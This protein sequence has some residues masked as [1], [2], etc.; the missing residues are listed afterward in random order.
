M[1]EGEKNRHTLG[2]IQQGGQRLSKSDPKAL[3]YGQLGSCAD[4]VEADVDFARERAW[5]VH[6]YINEDLCTG[7]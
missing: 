2:I 1:K 4:V 5:N 3:S 7:I 6:K